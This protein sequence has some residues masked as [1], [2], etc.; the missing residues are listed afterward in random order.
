MMVVSHKFSQVLYEF[1]SCE[2]LNAFWMPHDYDTDYVARAEVFVHFR[3]ADEYFSGM[4]TSQC[5][6]FT[7][8]YKEFSSK[9]MN[10]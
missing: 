2:I 7:R 6:Q 1:G 3:M 10:Q 4:E 9:N 8:V 5:T